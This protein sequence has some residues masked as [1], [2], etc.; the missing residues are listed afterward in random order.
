MKSPSG[1]GCR[2]YNCQCILACQHLTSTISTNSSSVKHVY[3]SNR[4][5]RRENWHS[6]QPSAD[7]QS[8]HLSGTSLSQRPHEE[9]PFGNVWSVPWQSTQSTVIGKSV[10]SST[11]DGHTRPLQTQHQSSVGHE[12]P[13]DHRSEQDARA[14][15]AQAQPHALPAVFSTNE[16]EWQKFIPE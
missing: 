7:Q 9:P 12:R 16:L 4:D 8:N 14:F 3:G 11:K 2:T 10:P 5:S 1:C 13:T 6:T 15:W